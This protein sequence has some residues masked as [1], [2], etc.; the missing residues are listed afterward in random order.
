MWKKIFDSTLGLA[1]TLV[2]S[3]IVIITLSGETQKIAIWLTIGA[4]VAHY[5]LVLMN[6]D[7]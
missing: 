5:A 7:E 3:I 2:G 1:W 4:L 6:K